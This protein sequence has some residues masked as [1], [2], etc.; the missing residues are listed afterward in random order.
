[1]LTNEQ[2]KQLEKT[3]S[4]YESEF[5]FRNLQFKSIEK[6]KLFVELFNKMEIEFWIRTTKISLEGCFICPDITSEQLDT[7]NE[8]E[9]QKNIREVIMQ[10]EPW[11]MP[12]DNIINN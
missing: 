10:L 2:Y 11:Y 3:Y 7:L 9:A 1:M 5:L 12:Y 6:L 8:T 4:E